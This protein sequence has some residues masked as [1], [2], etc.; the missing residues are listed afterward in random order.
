MK[1]LTFTVSLFCI[2]A[3]I[4]GCSEGVNVNGQ[5]QIEF[6]FTQTGE[7]ENWNI[8][9]K[10]NGTYFNIEKIIKGNHDLTILPKN[11]V[12]YEE[13]TV[14]I[15]IGEKLLGDDESGFIVQQ[16]KDGSFTIKQ[17]GFMRFDKNDKLWDEAITLVIKLGNEKD[18]IKLN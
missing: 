3:F 7:N 8:T 10:V 9:D 1:K 6:S 11:T 2:M 18:T 15:K 5:K 4:A 13:I 16:G 14:S 12:N 17:S